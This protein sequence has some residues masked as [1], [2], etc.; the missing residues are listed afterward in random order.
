M[1]N[2]LGCP[3]V[4]T[5]NHESSA[6]GNGMGIF[7]SC[8]CAFYTLGRHDVPD[9]GALARRWAKAQN[10]GAAT[11][12]AVDHRVYHVVN[13]ENGHEHEVEVS[14]GSGDVGPGRYCAHVLRVI[15]DLLS[16]RGY[17]VFGFGEKGAGCLPGFQVLNL[18]GWLMAVVIQ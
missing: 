3:T 17:T 1:T 4:Y 14:V 9:Q 8:D 6:S 16:D 7:C 2:N 10:I 18:D 5:V 11:Q 12:D 13:F 15:A